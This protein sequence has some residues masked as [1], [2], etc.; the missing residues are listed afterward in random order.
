M[1]YSLS[2]INSFNQCLTTTS[3]RS[4]TLFGDAYD[5]INPIRERAGLAQG[6]FRTA[7]LNERIIELAFENHRWFDLKRTMSPTELAAFLNAHGELERSNPTTDRGGIP[8]S[9]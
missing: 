3:K 4:K 7:V 2:I 8:F 1:N 9:V 5:K 6:S